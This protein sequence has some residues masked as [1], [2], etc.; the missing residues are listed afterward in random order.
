MI[1]FLV[2]NMIY[3][4]KEVYLEIIVLEMITP[5]LILKF[6]YLIDDAIFL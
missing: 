4:A 6:K 1:R 3:K 5:Y 2:V